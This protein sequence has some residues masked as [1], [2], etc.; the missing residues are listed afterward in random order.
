MSTRYTV[1]CR[2]TLMDIMDPNVPA[3]HQ[4]HTLCSIIVA[5][6][7]NKWC[8]LRGLLMLDSDVI[9]LAVAPL[10]ACTFLAMLFIFHSYFGIVEIQPKQ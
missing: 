7:S 8:I 1:Q 9:C 6:K 3:R 10:F 5:N 4:Q 2:H